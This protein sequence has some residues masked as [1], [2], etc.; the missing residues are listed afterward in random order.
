[1][2]GKAK[3]SSGRRVLMSTIVLLVVSGISL[4]FAVQA[5]GQLL[6]AFDVLSLSLFLVFSYITLVGI[7]SLATI[8]YSIDKL[9][10]RQKRTLRFLEVCREMGEGRE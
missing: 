9:S 2:S 4:A 8:F 1:M 3:M 10:G 6:K 7:Y 5:S